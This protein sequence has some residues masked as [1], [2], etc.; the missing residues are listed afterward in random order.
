MCLVARDKGRRDAKIPKPHMTI[1][2]IDEL[3]LLLGAES[4]ITKLRNKGTAV[5]KM[6]M[7]Q[8]IRRTV[9]ALADRSRI[10]NTRY[11]E[12]IVVDTATRKIAWYQ[13][14]MLKVPGLG[15][16][17]FSRGLASAIH[18]YWTVAPPA[19]PRTAP[20]AAAFLSVRQAG[21]AATM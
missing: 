1:V 15:R 20:M 12:Q 11:A 16:T 6:P 9:S 17:Q 8:R 13:P 5:E 19:A 21:S 3:V 18:E 7:G 10:T 4:R 14:G 2:V